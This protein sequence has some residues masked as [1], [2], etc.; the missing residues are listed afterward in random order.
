MA[1][2][3]SKLYSTYTELEKIRDDRNSF[4]RSVHKNIV[5]KKL[6]KKSSPKFTKFCQRFVLQKNIAAYSRHRKKKKGTKL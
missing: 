5:K 2:H 4:E 6:R 1:Q 3:S